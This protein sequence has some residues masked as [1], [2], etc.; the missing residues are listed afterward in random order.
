MLKW[1]VE[2]VTIEY[3]SSGGWK[4]LPKIHCVLL[5]LR[6]NRSKDDMSADLEAR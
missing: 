5:D 4:C 2:R 3:G 6:T 1:R